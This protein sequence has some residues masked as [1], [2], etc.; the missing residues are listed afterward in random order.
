MTLS[1]ILAPVCFY[2]VLFAIGGC[3]LGPLQAFSTAVL[4]AGALMLVPWIWWAPKIVRNVI[5]GLI[6]FVI[7][8]VMSPVI[9]I[10]SLPVFAALVIIRSQQNG[11]ELSDKMGR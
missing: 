4:A 3:H 10:L 2:I 6:M 9:V 5:L 11:G 8:A 1:V 7:A